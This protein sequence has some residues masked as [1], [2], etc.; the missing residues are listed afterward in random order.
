[1]RVAPA[2]SAAPALPCLALVSSGSLVNGYF[3]HRYC[4]EC[5][6]CADL[7]FGASE[8]AVRINPV[9]SGLAEED[10]SAALSAKRLPDALIV[11]KVRVRG[12][13]FVSEVDQQFDSSTP[14]VLCLAWLLSGKAGE[15]G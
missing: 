14:G 12:C 8:A 3:H 5:N 11:P 7:D 1:M 15:S 6:A 2:F 13:C 10:L 9:S 4:H